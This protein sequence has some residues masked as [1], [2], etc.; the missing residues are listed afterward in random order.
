MKALI[1]KSYLLEIMKS[2]VVKNENQEK[3]LALKFWRIWNEGAYANMLYTIWHGI[4]A[5]WDFLSAYK[6]RLTD[7]YEIFL[8][9][10]IDSKQFWYGRRSINLGSL[11]LSVVTFT[12]YNCAIDNVAEV[13]IQYSAASYLRKFWWFLN[14]TKFIFLH[15]I[16]NR[17]VYHEC[18]STRPW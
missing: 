8:S 15:Q 2:F 9:H 12:E 10:L 16:T 6:R 7:L 17:N 11:S 13:K 4:M 1:L 5:R 3:L 18:C 14:A